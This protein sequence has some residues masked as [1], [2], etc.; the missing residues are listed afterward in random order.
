[1]RKNKQDR[2]KFEEPLR[3]PEPILPDATFRLLPEE[4]QAIFAAA[5]KAA[6]EALQ[7]FYMATQEAGTYTKLSPRWL[8]EL[9]VL[10]GGPLYLKVGKRVLYRKDHLDEWLAAFQCQSTA[11]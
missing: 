10:G 1:M 4:I 9:R 6:W 11:E 8:E 2:P 3:N 7:S 5:Q